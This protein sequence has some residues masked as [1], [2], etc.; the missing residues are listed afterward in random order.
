MKS[1][2]I[3]WNITKVR[4]KNKKDVVIVV[5]IQE[6]VVQ[7]VALV[8]TVIVSRSGTSINRS[9]YIFENKQQL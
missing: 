3:E 7:S 6:R 4:L 1:D 9:K 2:W 5:K 8:F